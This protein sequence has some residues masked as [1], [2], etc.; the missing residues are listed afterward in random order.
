MHKLKERTKTLVVKLTTNQTVRIPSTIV[1]QLRLKNGMDFAVESRDEAIMLTP[2]VRVPKS[3]AYYWTPEWQAAERKADDD[4]KHGRVDS[5][6][7]MEDLVA[8]LAK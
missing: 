4:I 5:F 3:Q 8:D 6:G 2:L 7:F 1:R